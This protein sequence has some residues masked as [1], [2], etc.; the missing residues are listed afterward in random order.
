MAHRQLAVDGH[1]LQREL[2]IEP[3]PEIGRL[4]HRLLDAV[5][6]D[7]GLNDRERLLDLARETRAAR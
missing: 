3:G 1:D 6:E 7:P 5:V 2:G 4:L